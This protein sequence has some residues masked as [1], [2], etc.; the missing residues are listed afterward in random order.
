MNF[1][2]I[3]YI[4]LNLFN[5]LTNLFKD[6]L[7]IKL[8]IA[9]WFY[10]T[11]IHVYLYC[12]FFLLTFDVATGITASIKK[13]DKF[14]SRYLKKGLLEKLALYIILIL[15]AFAL[16]SVVKT[17][18]N[19]EKFF[20]VFF[21]SLLISIYEV[22]SICENIL[23][24]NPSLVFLSSIIKLSKSLNDKAI[25]TAQSKIDA[26]EFDKAGKKDEVKPDETKIVQ[27]ENKS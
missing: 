14:T 13:G 21:V 9:V 7:V 19:W 26:I 16:E 24:I 6:N 17:I 3:K 8:M 20:V 10:F 18:F 5:N 15:A 27:E 2:Y 22:V 1:T 25:E 4:L 11:G 12:V 23:I